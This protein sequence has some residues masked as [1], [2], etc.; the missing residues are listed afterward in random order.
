LFVDEARELIDAI[1]NS[2]AYP[3]VG[4]S[5]FDQLVTR[6]VEKRLSNCEVLDLAPVLA[7]SVF[8][9][10]TEPL[11]DELERESD[12]FC[13]V[14]FMIYWAALCWRLRCRCSDGQW[15]VLRSW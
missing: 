8:K 3:I 2:V 5:C 11:F 4:K 6:I 10:F 14:R 15:L 9:N 13:M 12:G 1:S 7:D